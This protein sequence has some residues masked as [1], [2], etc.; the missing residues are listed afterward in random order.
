[1][2]KEGDLEKIRELQLLEALEEEPEIRQVD[3]AAQ[4]PGDQGL[5]QGQTD[6]P[7]ALALPPHSPG[8]CGEGPTDPAVSSRLHASLPAGA[9]GSPTA[10]E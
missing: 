9:A 10:A 2:G 3:L 8:F 5:C 4:A 7:V 6:W 1:M